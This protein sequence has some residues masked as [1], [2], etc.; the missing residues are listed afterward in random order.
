MMSK[1]RSIDQSVPKSIRTKVTKAKSSDLLGR[2]YPHKKKM[3]RKEYESLK[4]DLQIEL[5]KMNKWVKKG[6]RKVVILFEGRDAGGKGGTI[7]R[8]TEHINPRGARVV[9]LEKPSRTERTQWFFQRY[10]KQL[11]IDGEIVFFD[12]SWY[13]R[14]VVEPVMGFCTPEETRI[15]LEEAPILEKMMI[16]SG[17]QLF[18]FW[19][20]VSRPEQYR[21]FKSREMDRLKQWKLSPVDLDSLSKWDEYTKAIDQMFEYTDTPESPWHVVR[22]DDKKRARLNCMLHVLNA[23]PYDNKDTSIVVAPDPRILGPAKTMYESFDE[24]QSK[25]KG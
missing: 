13:N 17:I 18:K 20:S 3:E 25:S 12:R 19:F 16:Q 10:I 1:S 24:K 7:K 23:L 15:F 8:F 6:G 2:E 9:A 4:L 11:P 5:L 22:S 14:A 21:R